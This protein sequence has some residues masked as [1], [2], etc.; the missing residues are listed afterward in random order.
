MAQTD[1]ANVIVSVIYAL[2]SYVFYLIYLNK[3]R[4]ERYPDTPSPGTVHY[5]KLEKFHET[6][7]KNRAVLYRKTVAR[8]F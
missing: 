5:K 6:R 7:F 8:D 1:V 2:Q 4:W 3:G